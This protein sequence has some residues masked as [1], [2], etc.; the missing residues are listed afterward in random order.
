MIKNS[1]KHFHTLTCEI[2][3]NNMLVDLKANYEIVHITIENP[4]WFKSLILNI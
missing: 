2:S 1:I 3:K 4:L